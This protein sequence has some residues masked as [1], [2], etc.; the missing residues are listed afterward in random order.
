MSILSLPVGAGLPNF[1]NTRFG[2]SSNTQAFNSI[3][4]K[5]TQTEEWPGAKW[6]VTYNLPPMTA[7]QAGAWKSF[8]VKLRGQ[9]GRFY[10]FDPDYA[11]HGPQG[12]PSGAPLVA[13]AGQTGT[14]LSTDGWDADMVI[15]KEGDYFAFDTLYGRELKM[16][17]EDILSDGTGAADLVFEPPIRNAPDNNAP[18]IV[19]NP[20]CIMKLDDDSIGW[21]SDQLMHYGFSFSATEVFNVT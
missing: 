6:S 10:G 14:T 20:S 16:I 21:D 19:D 2:L 13:G 8:L 18:I 1:T 15:F 5:A 7:K 3:F 9:A 12:S 11:V 17:T 4:T